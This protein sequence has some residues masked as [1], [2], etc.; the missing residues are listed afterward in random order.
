M[1]KGTLNPAETGGKVTITIAKKVHCG[2][3]KVVATLTATLVQGSGD[4][5]M[6]AVNWAGGSAHT[7][8]YITACVQKTADLAGACA[9]T[10]IK[11]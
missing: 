11:L 5:S 1:I 2:H 3:I 6:Y 9:K 7:F 8:Y 4:S 10:Q